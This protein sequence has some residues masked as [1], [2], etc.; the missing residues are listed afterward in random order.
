MFSV[1]GL[2]NLSISW[3]ILVIKIS[4]LERVLDSSLDGHLGEMRD[5]GRLVMVTLMFVMKLGMNLM[6][7]THGR[8]F[9]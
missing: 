7:S 2:N 3:F 5:A 6:Y 9:F 1:I 4:G 8:I